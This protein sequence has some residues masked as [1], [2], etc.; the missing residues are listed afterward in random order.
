MTNKKLYRSKEN[1]VIGGICGGIGEY[2]DIDPTIIRV[3]FVLMAIARGGGICLYIVLLFIIPKK[4]KPLSRLGGL[5]P[6]K[7]GEKLKK[8]KGNE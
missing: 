1:R 6:L 2:F 3:I 8:E 7:K 5:L 4:T